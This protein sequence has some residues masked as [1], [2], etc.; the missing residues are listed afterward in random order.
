MVNLKERYQI[1]ETNLGPMISESRSSV[2]DVMEMEAQGYDTA[3][4]AT[5]FN[6]T[7]LQVETALEYI[8]AH[9]N[10]LTPILYELLAKKQEREAYHRAV[11][12]RI[13]AEIAQLPMTQERQTFY[14]L[15]EK[16]RARRRQENGHGHHSQ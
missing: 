16:N 7:V 2:Y 10:Q 3:E 8:E 1:L 9:R 14:R 5:I 4:I 6:L 15:L 12:E 13:Q 11:Q